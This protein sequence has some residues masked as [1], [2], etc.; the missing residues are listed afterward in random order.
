MKKCPFCAEE[1][2][3]EAIKCRF[4]GEMLN[5]A[6]AQAETVLADKRPS[7]KSYWFLL[8]LGILTLILLIGFVFV[9]YVVWDRFSRQYRVTTKRVIAKS[10]F[11][12]KTLDEI[13]IA[14]IRSINVKQSFFGR[15]LNYGDI[16]I[17][18][19][20]TEGVEVT[21]K[22]I[23]DPVRFKELI[24]SQNKTAQPAID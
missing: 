18:T 14:H 11:L 15:V 17:G 24:V 22:G 5:K 7:W 9:L 21:V 2:Q 13:N 1:I 12:S 3:D 23:S 16:L 10:G 6:E 20:G 19:A 4:C 8:M